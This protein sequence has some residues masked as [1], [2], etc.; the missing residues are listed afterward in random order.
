MR[1]L[2]LESTQTLNNFSL[3]FFVVCWLA[4]WPCTVRCL[5]VAYHFVVLLATRT[6]TYLGGGWDV[7]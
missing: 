4:T 1:L 7:S 5:L 3:A 2:S 6:R